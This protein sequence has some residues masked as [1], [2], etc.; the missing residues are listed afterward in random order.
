MAAADL[1]KILRE[2]PHYRSR[3]TAIREIPSREARCADPALP[4]PGAIQ[5][6][7]DL[8]GIRLYT[9]QAQALDRIREGRHLILTTPTASGKTL[10][11]TLPV[12]E[13]QLTDPDATALFLYPTKALA[14]DQLK[15][16]RELAEGMCIAA[17]P[18]I[19]DGDTPAS[20]RPRIRD[21]SRIILSNPHELHQVLPWHHR[22][23]RFLSHLQVVV[24]DE[25]HRYRGVFGSHMAMLLRRLRRTAAFYGATPQF[26]LSTATIANPQEFSERL[27][28][29]PF[30]HVGEDG[31]PRG[32]KHFVLYNPFGNGAAMASPHRETVALFLDSLSC[33][34]QTLC[35]TISRRMAELAALRART[36]LARTRA[37][38]PP[39]SIAAYRAG[40]LPEERREI[41]RKLKEGILRGLVS[42]NAL[43]VGI[44]IGS[45]D[46]A[47]LSGFPG[48]IISTWQQAGRAGRRG[49]D[50]VAIL[51]AFQ[52]MLDQYFM[53]HP[54]AFFA[55][56]PEHAIV[57][58]LNPYILS[59]HLLCA[60]SELPVSPGRDGNLWG[61]D[62]IPVAR[63]LEAA[64][65]LRSTPQGYVYCGRGRAQEAVHLDAVTGETFRMVCRG[66]ILETLDRGQAYREAHRGA[67][68]LH[69]G[70]TYLVEEMNLSTRE[71][72]V[73]PADVDYH[74]EPVK[75]V[76]LRVTGVQSE[77]ESPDLPLSFGSV[78]VTEQYTAY[79]IV[80][81]DTVVALEPLDLPPLQ[82]PTR[83]F[84]FTLSSD[85]ATR[86][87]AGGV[88]L[89]GALHGAEHALIGVAPLPLMCDRRDIGGLSTTSH[90]DTGAPTVFVYDGYEGGIGL[91]EKGYERFG[92]LAAMARDVVTGCRC[93]EGCPAC[94]YSPKCGNDNTPLDKTG[95]SRV[96]EA[97]SAAYPP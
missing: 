65:L 81:G 60:A 86:I 91:S 33:D 14:N 87:A 17:D 47:I 77:R 39:E 88:D 24:I 28:G 80:K 9:H 51:V 57:D 62:P 75:A 19:Y 25:A 63:T 45:L 32:T 22:W 78:E 29:L 66:R 96:L 70:E 68:V 43:E 8:K 30:V 18:S 83:A 7:L 82:F 40:Y 31:S 6:Y 74:T 34:L 41:E 13:R 26:V 2:V 89:A 84:W 48:S 15:A 79:R 53:H 71:I 20:R 85:L 44:D 46:A 4:L 38:I 16:I 5:G 42:T 54:E 21:H 23:T 73:S 67:V 50:S 64:R 10:A 35:F 37:V 72:R 97:A 94:L 95:A 1:L 92:A 36:G 55:Q 59:G 49:G 11:F 27:T 69:Q 52:D 90:P 93:T 12:L 3:V 56:T 61:S 58:L 76:D